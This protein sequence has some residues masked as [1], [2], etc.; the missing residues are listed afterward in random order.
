MPDYMSNYDVVCG[1]VYERVFV[2]F[3]DYNKVNKG[4]VQGL[5]QAL[6]IAE[7][8]AMPKMAAPARNKAYWDKY[9]SHSDN[10]VRNTQDFFKV[11]PPAWLSKSCF[12]CKSVQMKQLLLNH[13]T[14]S[15]CT[16]S[17]HFF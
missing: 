14:S 2:R 10:F 5:A 6:A 7:T 17:I 4:A 15:F 3:P 8:M 12:I 1:Y 16:S 11:W 9:L 13:V